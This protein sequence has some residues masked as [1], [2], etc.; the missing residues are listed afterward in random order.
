MFLILQDVEDVLVPRW[1][2]HSATLVK[3]LTRAR[4]SHLSPT[5]QTG[6]TSYATAVSKG[7]GPATSSKNSAAKV[8]NKVAK[9]AFA[10][11]VALPAEKQPSAIATLLKT[12]RCTEANVSISPRD[13]PAKRAPL[14]HINDISDVKNAGLKD[15]VQ[16]LT[17]VQLQGIKPMAISG[18]RNMIAQAAGIEPNAIVYIRRAGRNVELCLASPEAAAKVRRW[19]VRE[20]VGPAPPHSDAYSPYDGED[21]KTQESIVKSLAMEAAQAREM[22]VILK[23]YLQTPT[24][25]R[26]AFRKELEARTGTK[27]RGGPAEGARAQ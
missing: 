14:T 9:Q 26:E 15:R 3:E 13:P 24:P 27:S 19:F 4:E 20:D 11:V 7:G 12:G 23:L 2:Q 22:A 6:P 5:T 1:R 10:G 17:T 8:A 21:S 18:L 16:Q 25:L